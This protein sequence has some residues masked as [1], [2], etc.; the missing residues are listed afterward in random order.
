MKHK[1]LIPLLALVLVVTCLALACASETPPPALGKTVTDDLGREIH[2]D[3]IPQRIISLSPSNTEVL[4]AL[5]LGDRVIGV[6]E[7]CDYPPE[8]EALKAE[9]KLTVVG[10]FSTPDFEKVIALNPD[11]ILASTIHQKEV[12]PKLEARGFTVFT[13]AAENIDGVLVDIAK[14]GEITGEEQQATELT[15][16][17]RGRITEMGNRVKGLPEPRVFFIIWH[18]PLFTAGSETIV[19]SLIERAGGVNIFQD[20]TEYKTVDLEAVIGRNPQVIIACTGHGSARNKPL[21]W[22]EEEPRLR[23]T[24]ALRDNRVY[25]VDADL[26]TRTGPR[27]IDAL[28]D[29]TRLIHPEVFDE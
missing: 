9:G 22:A 24:A 7:F 20:L 1:W 28:E 2:I 21:I 23:E 17:L 25:L 3:G 15:D 13:L 10:G 6:T 14:V 11:L 4:F 27:V 26:V 29:L 12:T 8:A 18:D 19:N 16:H 5:G